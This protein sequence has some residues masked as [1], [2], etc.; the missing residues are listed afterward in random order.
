MMHLLTIPTCLVLP[1]EH[2]A[3]TTGSR[4]LGDPAY[5][6]ILPQY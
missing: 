2:G 5:S 1:D 6:E 4:R 3:L